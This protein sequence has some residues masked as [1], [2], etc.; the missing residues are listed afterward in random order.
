MHFYAK[1]FSLALLP[2]F[3]TACTQ[4]LPKCNSKDAKNLISQLVNQRQAIIGQFVEIKDVEEI[5]FN[6]ESEIRVCV[7]QLTTTRLTEEIDYS[8]KWQNKEQNKFYLEI[9]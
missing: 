5:A 6:K 9:I 8:I 1:L 3:L 2:L 7:A 4:Q